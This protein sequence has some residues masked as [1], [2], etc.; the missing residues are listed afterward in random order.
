MEALGDRDR[1]H[2]VL[3][4]ALVLACGLVPEHERE[5]Q[6][7]ALDTVA[8]LTLDDPLRAP[9]PASGGPDL[10]RRCEVHPQHHRDACGRK[11]SFAFEVCVVGALEGRQAFGHLP[12]QEGGHRQQHKVVGSDRRLPIRGREGRVGIAP[13]TLRVRISTLQEVVHRLRHRRETYSREAEPGPNWRDM[14]GEAGQARA[15]ED[16]ENAVLQPVAGM[17]NVCSLGLDLLGRQLRSVGVV[18]VVGLVYP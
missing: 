4:A 10:A 14:A 13:P 9:E 3:V 15:S 12:R 5:Q 16:P 1:F 6:V 18:Q 17:P 8:T 11:R 7:S 2:G